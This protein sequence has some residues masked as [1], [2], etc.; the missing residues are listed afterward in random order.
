MDIY[1]NGFK[2]KYKGLFKSI[3]LVGLL[4]KKLKIDNGILIK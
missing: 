3:I 1:I 2:N 4:F